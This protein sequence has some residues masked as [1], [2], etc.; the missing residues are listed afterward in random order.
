MSENKVEI[1]LGPP[2]TGKTTALLDKVDTYLAGG[3]LF[4]LQGRP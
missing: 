4:P 2:G 1:I 3:D